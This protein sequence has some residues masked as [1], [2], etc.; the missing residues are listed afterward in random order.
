[1]MSKS[2]CDK[3]MLSVTST[4]AGDSSSEYVES[5]DEKMFLDTEGLQDFE[6]NTS[7]EP[8]YPALDRSSMPSTR[9]NSPEPM[10]DYG[11]HRFWN[12]DSGYAAEQ[13]QQNALGAGPMQP[14]V[15]PQSFNHMQSQG[16]QLPRRSSRDPPAARQYV[17]P[18]AQPNQPVLFVPQN[19]RIVFLPGASPTGM[20]LP[21]NHGGAMPF[22]FQTMPTPSASHMPSGTSTANKEPLPTKPSAAAADAT[23]TPSVRE[24]KEGKSKNRRNLKNDSVFSKM[25]AEKKEALCKYIYELM[26]GK[27]FTSQEGYLIVDVFSEVWKDIGDTTE[28]WRVA[29]HRFVNLIRSAPHH[30][31][32]FRRGIPVANHCGWFARKGDK[33]VR[34]VL[35]EEK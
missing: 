30:F 3:S 23:P 34:L 11:N 13:Y 9:E 32:L 33:M 35:E 7:F 6:N 28:G 15:A 2:K 29:Q 18:P 14:S 16:H 26:K 19:Q 17:S 21:V 5:C 12:R 31:R 25:S 27:G 24:Q 22:P 1:M 10:W 4:Y 8:T 20:M